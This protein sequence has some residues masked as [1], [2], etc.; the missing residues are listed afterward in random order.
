MHPNK[1]CK[2]EKILYEVKNI[3]TLYYHDF[4]AKHM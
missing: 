1:S 2:H 3:T 4:Q